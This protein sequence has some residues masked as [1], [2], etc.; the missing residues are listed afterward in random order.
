MVIVTYIEHYE[1]ISVAPIFRVG[2]FLT[3]V[4][5]VVREI[6]RIMPQDITVRRVVVG[7]EQELRIH[8]PVITELA[9]WLAAV[10]KFWVVAS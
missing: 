7:R 10:G 5:I 1:A 2:V 6:V 9:W 4:R 3:L 8:W